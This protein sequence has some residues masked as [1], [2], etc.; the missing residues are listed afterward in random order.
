MSKEDPMFSECNTASDQ[1][2]PIL[3]SLTEIETKEANSDRRSAKYFAVCFT[4][5]YVV[6]FIPF[7]YMGL[8]SSMTFDN[9]RMTVSVGLWIMFLTFL[10]SF[11]MPISVYLMWSRY[12]RCQ[13]QKTRFFCALPILTFVGVSLIIAALRALLRYFVPL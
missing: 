3:T 10:I 12:L 6:L 9:P 13:Y 4:I 7:F 5:I 2:P 8:F 11:S 1:E